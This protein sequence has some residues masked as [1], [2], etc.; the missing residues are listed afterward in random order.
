MTAGI[1]DQASYN[2]VI[3]IDANN[4]GSLVHS[5]SSASG[6]F[7]GGDFSRYIANSNIADG[8]IS[9][10]FPIGDNAQFR[11]ANISCPTNAPIS[12]GIITSKHTYSAY[13]YNTNFIDGLATVLKVND[14]KWAFSQTGITGGVFNMS[15]L[16]NNMSGITD[17]NSLRI[18][19]ANSIVG[20][21]GTNSGNASAPLIARINLTASDLNNNFYIGSVDDVGSPLPITLLSFNAKLEKNTFVL[22]WETASELDN[23][24]FTIEKT[25][26]NKNFEVVS[27]I[28]G[29]GTS[30]SKLR[31][32]VVDNNPYR[33][34]FYYRLRQTDYDGTETS[35][36]LL[37]VINTSD[38]SPNLSV[39]PNPV[40]NSEI[41]IYLNGFE[42]GTP[43][44]MD[45]THIN[46]VSI[47]QNQ[48]KIED[49]NEHLIV[50]ISNLIPGVYVLN[51]SSINGNFNKRILV[52]E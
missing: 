17:V 15:L 20:Q 11:P 24:F 4:P 21:A 10:Y 1:V 36:N 34:T 5:S 9:G 49:L 18:T 50:K 14:S 31:Y 2:V 22:T 26:D 42:S 25:L 51:L 23:D 32:S 46:G 13:A 39:Y 37:Q 3:G 38:F 33:G 40:V 35:F 7:F 41:N 28:Q 44:K 8:N 43:I 29:A 16:A 48:F 52:K 47:Y 30:K 12:G 6:W 27:K 45:I 19:K